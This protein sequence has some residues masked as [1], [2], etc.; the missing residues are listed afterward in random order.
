M[1]QYDMEMAVP[2]KEQNL[3]VTTGHGIIDLNEE[4]FSTRL[5]VTTREK[6]WY[7]ADY[8]TLTSGL[9]SID[10]TNLSPSVLVLFGQNAFPV[11]T[12]KIGQATIGAAK[13]GKVISVLNKD[14]SMIAH[15]CYTM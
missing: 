14:Q 1:M 4:H 5:D 12:N 2:A 3:V 11:N 13:Y 7:A 8:E 9:E 15:K 6:P 10:G